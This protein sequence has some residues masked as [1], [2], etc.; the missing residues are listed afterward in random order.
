MTESN[1]HVSSICGISRSFSGGGESAGKGWD[2]EVRLLRSQSCVGF[3]ED[4]CTEHSVG[5]DKR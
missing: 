3:N 1:N 4:V 2:P 5:E